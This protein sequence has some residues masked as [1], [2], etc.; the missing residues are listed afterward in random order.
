MKAGRQHKILEIIRRQRI[1]TQDE[2]SS[3][4]KINGYKVTQATVSRDIKE[5]GLIKIPFEDNKFYYVRPGENRL[6]HSRERLKRVFLDAVIGFDAS[7]N[8]IIIKTNPGGAQGVA[9]AIDQAGW[10]EI[11]GTVGGDDTILVVVKPRGA[12]GAVLKRFGDLLGG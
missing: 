12:A 4:L 2:L 5:L 10:D 11:I 3:E 6:P 1:G 7:E 8:L 9:L